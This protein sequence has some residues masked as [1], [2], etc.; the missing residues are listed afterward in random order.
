MKVQLPVH[1]FSQFDASIQAEYRASA[2]GPVTA[3]VLLNYISPNN[4]LLPNDLYRK[5]EGTRI[6]L[7][8]YRFVRNLQKILGSDWTVKRCHLQT[9]LE[10]LSQ[11]R[12]IALKFD[13]YFSFH[14]RKKYAYSYHWVPLIGYELIDD[15]LF[16][17]VHDNGGRNRESQIRKTSYAKNAKVLTFVQVTPK[18]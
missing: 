15:E 3:Y 13:K 4:S 11:G 10:E 2:C 6:G 5:L 12:P 17:I 9:A 16:L 8:T 7:F 14:W 1:G 18:S